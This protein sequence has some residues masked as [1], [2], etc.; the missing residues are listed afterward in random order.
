M[1]AERVAVP[2]EY[3]HD[4]P[5]HVDPLDAVSVEPLAVAVHA[6]RVG[7]VK[8]DD[9]VAVIG[10]GM[11]GL[12][13]VQL[14][15]ARGAHVLAV[16]VRSEALATAESL[17]AARTLQIDSE[18]TIPTLAAEWSPRVVFETAGSAN[19]VETALRIVSN[20]GSVV[21][22]GLATEPMSITPVRFVRRGLSLLSSLIYDHPRDFRCAIDLVSRGAL[23]PGQ[24]VRCVTDL[25]RASAAFPREPPGKP[26]STFG[27]S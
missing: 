9:P 19:A 25:E 10:C 20:G 12:L 11:Q 1:F 5:A 14:A 21:I 23:N 4:L 18:T 26:S 8:T 3:V 22:V 13:L 7:N 15:V 16:D 2:A 24:H 27:M 6:L 17:G